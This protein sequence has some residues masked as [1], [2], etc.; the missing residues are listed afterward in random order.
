MKM[1]LRPKPRPAKAATS[2]RAW[3]RGRQE[4]SEGLE[5]LDVGDSSGGGRQPRLDWG[6]SP[7]C[8]SQSVG[9][10]GVPSSSQAGS[11][12]SGGPNPGFQFHSVCDL[13]LSET[14]PPHPH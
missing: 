14:V 6:S 1:R 10:G 12:V 4:A 8:G 11:W 2:N 7:A 5:V 13:P 3:G 9:K